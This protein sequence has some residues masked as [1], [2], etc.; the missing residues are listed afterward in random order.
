[1]SVSISRLDH[2]VLTVSDVESTCTFYTTVLGMERVTFGQGRTAVTFGSQKINLH[3]QDQDFEPKALNPVP[4]S[5][6]LC[7]IT[8]TPVTVAVA[9]L[10]KWGVTVEEGPVY[11]TGSRGNLLS[12]YF[13][14]PDGNLIELSNEVQHPGASPGSPPES[15]R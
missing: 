8:E 3:Q 9:W 7:L 13:R 5:A 15:A 12:L 4:G 11:R 10:A 6:D 2:I 14:D 1:M